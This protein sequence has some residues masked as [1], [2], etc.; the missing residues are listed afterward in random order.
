MSKRYVPMDKW[1][2]EKLREEI[3]REF[4]HWDDIYHNGCSDPAWPDGVNLNLIRNHIIYEYRLLQ[5]KLDEPIQT[6]LFSD[7]VGIPNARP[8]PATV[9]NNYM[10]PKQRYPERAKRVCRVCEI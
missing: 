6:S 10:A 3:D 1:P 7:Y 9:P 2:P 5:E 8:I 4:A